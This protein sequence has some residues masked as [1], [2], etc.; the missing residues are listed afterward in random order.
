MAETSELKHMVMSF[1]VSELQVLLGFAGKNKSGRK[2]ELQA[3]ALQL[4]KNGCD[5]PVQ[6]KIK[7][8]YRR[9]Y[10]HKFH[11]ISP[12]H[13]TMSSSTTTT[14]SSSSNTQYSTN[15]RLQPTHSQGL[16]NL[17]NTASSGSQSSSL[18][19]H[20][21]VRLKHLPFYDVLDD[22]IKPTSLVPRSSSKFQE[23]YYVY[24][25][26][27]REISQI[28]SARDMRPGA[29]VEYPVQVQLRL[30]LS[31]TSCEQDD[32]YPPN[33][34]IKVNGKMAPLPSFL[35]QAK[36]GQEPK[37]PS[38]PIN[39]T[40]STRL[41]PTVPNQIHVSWAADFG[42]GYAIAVRL[43]KQ[44]NADILLQ[45]LKSSKGVRN[46]DHSRAMIKEKLAHDPDSEIATTSLRVSLI[47]PLGKMRMSI[48]CRALTCNHLQCF[49]VSLY[50]QMNE[51]KPTW[52]CPVCDK[53]APYDSLIIDGL[54][55][56]I[57]ASSPITDEIQ[58]SQDGS[59]SVMKREKHN[60]IITS[61]MNK[62][63]SPFSNHTAKQTSTV[64]SSKNVQMIDLTSDDEDEE[65]SP[66]MPAVKKGCV[67]PPL[68]TIE[69]TPPHTVSASLSLLSSNSSSN[70]S[71]CSSSVSS[72][73][74]NANLHAVSPPPPS[75]SY[76]FHSPPRRAS[77]INLSTS[78]GHRV[79]SFLS[80]PPPYPPPLPPLSSDELPT[81]EEFEEF[82]GWLGDRRYRP[83]YSHSLFNPED[84]I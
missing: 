66:C 55:T 46:A 14:S 34:C 64:K 52:I 49:D 73:S 70:S 5:T 3:R 44:L 21:D 33:L 57:L 35:P 25:L 11:V 69:N 75:P 9:R 17:N 37:R 36:I 2:H 19:V 72:C 1:R 18:P 48:P 67:S 45:R 27:P 71:S 80:R 28:T 79:P 62:M 39:V 16:L 7:N 47:C 61:P 83:D 4:L 40:G 54:F 74:S 77:P 12:P 60:E 56:E 58:F 22:L 8:L 13:A 31:E 26:S 6:I 59:W 24:H 32:H 68:I 38:R 84:L 65:D 51:K 23:A 10:P 78:S 82:L 63:L 76:H 50:L 20:P 81:E 41:S 42:R 53:Q 30:C 15:F 43:V 29:R